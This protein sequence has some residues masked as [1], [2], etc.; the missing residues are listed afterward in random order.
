MNQIHLITLLLTMLICGQTRAE[1]LPKWELGLGLGSLSIADYRGSDEY[2]THV[3]PIPFLIYRSKFFKADRDGVRSELFNSDQLAISISLNAS[4]ATSGSD[5]PLRQDLE[6][7][8]PTFELGPA[9]DINLSG[10]SLRQGWHLRLPAR[11][12]FA[13]DTDS[14]RQVG[15]LL[16]PHFVYRSNSFLK[17]WKMRYV[18]GAYFGDKD[19]HDY[20]YAVPPEFA[21]ANRPAFQADNGYSGLSTQITLTRRIGNI[22]YG[23]FLRYD[24]LKEA[25]FINSPL[26]ETENYAV[27]GFGINWVFGKSRDT[28]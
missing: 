4:L 11:T 22:W 17:N 12:V 18:I 7:L 28:L 16:N 20:F 2:N 6:E 24:N 26:V 3:F 8:D 14:L 1:S 5:N 27:L 21:T 15:W 10:A 9:L 19:Y 13:F 25:Q 23:G